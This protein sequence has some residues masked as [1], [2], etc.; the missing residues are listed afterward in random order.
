MTV[1]FVGDVY[2]FFIQ[3]SQIKN[4]AFWDVMPC[5]SSQRG[6]VASYC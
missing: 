4:V 6:S 2:L 5:I 3:V 1:T